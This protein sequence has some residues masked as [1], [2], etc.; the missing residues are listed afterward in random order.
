VH[1]LLR[2]GEATPDGR[3]AWVTTWSWSMLGVLAVDLIRLAGA[4]GA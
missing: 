1:H 3:P 4:L 2:P